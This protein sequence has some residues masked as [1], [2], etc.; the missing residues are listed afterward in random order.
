MR[1]LF[2]GLA[3]FSIA[4]VALVG[5]YLA[6][7]NARV[8]PPIV[9]TPSAVVRIF[10]DSPDR[11]AKLYEGRFVML[12]IRDGRYAILNHPPVIVSDPPAV[13]S[14]ITIGILHC[15]RDGTYTG[16]NCYFT[17]VIESAQHGE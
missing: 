5:V 2:A 14:N 3:V 17:L 8:E 10:R 9:V 16:D 4:S 15:R 11:A 1:R 13:R 7:C 6:G 12:S